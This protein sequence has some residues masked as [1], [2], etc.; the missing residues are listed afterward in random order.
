MKTMA[1]YAF[2]PMRRLRH[3]SFLTALSVLL[4]LASCSG[5]LSGEAG[6]DAA[7]GGT[8]TV[9]VISAEPEPSLDDKGETGAAAPETS[10]SDKPRERVYR[11]YRVQE[12]DSWGSIAELFSVTAEELAALN[13]RSPEGYVYVDELLRIPQ[14]ARIP[15]GLETSEIRV[16]L[17]PEIPQT[18]K[19]MPLPEHYD[20]Y[21]EQLSSAAKAKFDA[22]NALSPWTEDEK[23]QLA[24]TQTFAEYVLRKDSPREP[25][26]DADI[27]GCFRSYDDE[28]PLFVQWDERWAYQNYAEDP[29]AISAC[30]PTALAMVYVDRTG[31]RSMNPS[32]M[33]DWASENGYAIP[34]NGS[35]WLLM[36]EGAEKLGLDVHEL[37]LDEASA[38]D[39]LQDGQRLIMLVGP[40]IFT[41]GG[42]FVVIR[43]Y[44]DG[45]FRIYDP[46]NVSYAARAFAW[47]TFADQI[48]AIWAY[49]KLS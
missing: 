30:G 14:D 21:E 19:N 44:E 12:G 24:R 3:L 5:K 34:N 4:M 29:A 16:V 42:H 43:A 48:N 26:R 41:S 49:P 18:L 11:G 8:P 46:F 2:C 13:E 27:Q 28:M 25:Q 45:M 23:K 9:P 38:V 31:D 33:M 35:S 36:S 40:G 47:E 22:L 39:A 32:R 17:P 10:R 1:R 15:E 7:P 20:P 6:G 37:S